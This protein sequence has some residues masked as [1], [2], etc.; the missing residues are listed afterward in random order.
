MKIPGCGC[1]LGM[2]LGMVLFVV[3]LAAAAFGLYCWF[4]PQMHDKA[5]SHAEEKWEQVKQTG[6]EAL[7]RVREARPE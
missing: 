6:D 3:L 4:N 2:L 7:E 5:V 1:C